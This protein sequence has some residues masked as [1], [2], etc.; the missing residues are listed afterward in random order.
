MIKHKL[1]IKLIILLILIFSI[2]ILIFHFEKDNLKPNDF[3]ILENDIHLEKGTY[4]IRKNLY[5]PKNVVLTLNPGVVFK[6]NENVMIY[7]EGRIIAD[8]SRELPIIFEGNN[9]FWKGIKLVGNLKISNKKNFSWKEMENPNNLFYEDFG[10]IVENGSLFNNCI[11]EDIKYGNKI[12]PGESNF[13]ASIESYN[14]SVCISNSVFRNIEYIG[15]IQIIDSYAILFNNQHIS[16]MSHK[17]IHTENSEVLIFNNSVIAE[18]ECMQCNDG[19]WL[20]GSLSIVHSNKVIGKGD[21]GI[22]V[23]GGY[24]YLLNNLVK[25][26]K[27]EGIDVSNEFD[28]RA[29][30]R[31]FKPTKIVYKKVIEPSKF[32]I[33]NND[34]SNN[35]ME[36]IL[37]T[38]DALCMN[39]SVFGNKSIPIKTLEGYKDLNCM[40]YN[41]N[42]YLFYNINKTIPINN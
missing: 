13:R 35:S 7:V 16:K 33:F 31:K 11:F 19:M 9:S 12:I 25:N 36:D 39:N 5:I 2:I 34:L 10:L 21:D 15:E 40:D 18:M 28:E 6:I 24:A 20:I 26:N 22:D 37:I 41:I 23:K 32:M 27:D 14:Y 29:L 38:G 1:N 4:V 3:Q 30:I 42:Q 17:T 8:G